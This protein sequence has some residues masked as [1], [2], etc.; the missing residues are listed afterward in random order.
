MPDDGIVMPDQAQ[1]ATVAAPE[2][3]QEVLSAE[4]TA[5]VATAYSEEPESIEGVDESL[6]GRVSRGLVAGLLTAILVVAGGVA[7]AILL[8]GHPRASGPAAGPAP[9]TTELAEAPSA[10]P[11]IEQQTP[12]A[13][14]DAGYL[15]TVQRVGVGID[16]PAGAIEAGHGVCELRGL[17]SS[18]GEVADEIVRRNPGEMTYRQA[19]VA[20]TAALVAYCPW[21]T[22]H[23]PN[24]R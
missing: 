12:T 10:P 11:T 22:E 6:P 21:Y 2:P 24:D 5:R 23:P 20:V 18:S 17:G 3:T 9:A 16:D 15:A 1:D 7:A 14:A 4:E 13:N 8:F 19:V